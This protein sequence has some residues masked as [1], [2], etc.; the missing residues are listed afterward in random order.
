M[1]RADNLATFWSPRG[2]SRPVQGH[3]N[4]DCILQRPIQVIGRTLSHLYIDHVLIIEEDECETS[5]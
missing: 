3:R 1:R 2:L 5:L 4:N